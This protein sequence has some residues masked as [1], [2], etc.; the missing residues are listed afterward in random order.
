MG[1]F[2]WFTK[3]SG[4]I[5]KGFCNYSHEVLWLKLWHFSKV[6]VHARSLYEMVGH[7]FCF[8]DLVISHVYML[9]KGTHMLIN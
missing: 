5:M 7:V 3:V 9:Y 2:L 8:L 4:S 1:I 6:I